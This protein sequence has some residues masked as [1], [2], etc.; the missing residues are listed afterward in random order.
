M[1]TEGNTM[2]DETG[3]I[4]D[5]AKDF[6]GSGVEGKKEGEADA[7]ADRRAKVRQNMIVSVIGELDPDAEYTKSGKPDVKALEDLLGFAISATE[8]D[9][10]FAAFSAHKDAHAAAKEGHAKALAEKDREIK[11]NLESASKAPAAK[12]STVL[13]GE[14]VLAANRKEGKAV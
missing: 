9:A 10:A 6:K 4:T 3:K 13:T 14:H 7:A 1:Q 11:A 8:R 5:G 2:A 12:Q